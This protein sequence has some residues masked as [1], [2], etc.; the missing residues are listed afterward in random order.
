MGERKVNSESLDLVA[1][2][3]IFVIYAVICGLTL[4]I[5]A[6]M[7]LRREVRFGLSCPHAAPHTAP[8]RL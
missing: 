8:S 1:F 4:V 7:F 6:G 2:A 3:G 5:F